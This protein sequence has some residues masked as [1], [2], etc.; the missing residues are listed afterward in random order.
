GWGG[1]WGYGWRVRCG[2][3]TISYQHRD[4]LFDEAFERRQQLGPE[5][6]VDHAVVAGER[7]REH[8]REGNAAVFLL[9]RLPPRGADRK[10]RRLR[11]IDDGGKF[12]HA[13]HTEI[14]DSGGTT[15]VF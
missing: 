2:R 15:V 9:D 10:H 11:R 12:A 6:A 7:H 5:H 8:A 4:R 1:K 3:D 14:G 13:V